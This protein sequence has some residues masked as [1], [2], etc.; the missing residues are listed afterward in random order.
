MIKRFLPALLGLAALALPSLASA[1]MVNAQTS[2]TYTVAN[3]DCDPSGA[4][5][6]TFNNSAAVAVTLRTT[7]TTAVSTATSFGIWLT[8]GTA[9]TC[10][11]LAATASS[12]GVNQI[13]LTC[14][15]GGTIALGTGT[16]L[17][18]AATAGTIS[19][20]ADY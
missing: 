20:F 4:K 17:I 16:N 14:T 5:L 18:G 11:T 7:P 9:G 3:T 19:A 10:T 15:T 13:G 2:T 1:Q 12:N 8:A 6:L